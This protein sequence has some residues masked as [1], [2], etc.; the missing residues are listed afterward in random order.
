MMSNKADRKAK[1]LAKT[2]AF[3]AMCLRQADR[4]TGAA[5][6]VYLDAAEKARK[7]IV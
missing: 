2:N 1:A 5:R 7:S 3:I 6:Q 4:K